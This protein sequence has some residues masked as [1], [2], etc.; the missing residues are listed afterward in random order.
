MPWTTLGMELNDEGHVVFQYLL[1]NG[2]GGIAPA[3]PTAPPPDIAP[4]VS[5]GGIVLAA[6]D[7][8]ERGLAPGARASI[9]G[10]G[11]GSLL[12]AASGASLPTTLDG[13]SVHVNGVAAPLFLPA[14]A[15]SIFKCHSGLPVL[16]RR[17]ALSEPPVRASYTAFAS[18]R[19]VPTV[20][21]V[22]NERF[23]HAVFTGPRLPV[24]ES[25]RSYI[26]VR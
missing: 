23:A 9:Y 3:T 4:V 22:L 7:E 24:R 21:L 11:L 10:W 15:R 25:G 1:A 20:N 12:T 18:N 19:Q 6:S 14:P 2:M 13:V 16:T 5:E 8:P 26:D 17:C